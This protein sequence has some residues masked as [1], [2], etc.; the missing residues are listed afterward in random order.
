M[1]APRLDQIEALGLAVDDGLLSREEAISSLTDW[2]EGGLTALGAADL[3][4]DWR[5]ARSRYET[6]FRMLP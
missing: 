2:S 6:A 4:E 5:S 1:T 3:L